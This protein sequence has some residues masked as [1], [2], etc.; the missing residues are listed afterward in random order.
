MV[1]SKITIA[2]SRG[3]S[4]LSDAIAF[5]KYCPKEPNA[6][7]Q[8]ASVLAGKGHLWQAYKLLS[9]KL[10]LSTDGTSSRFNM[11]LV[12]GKTAFLLGK[13]PLARSHFEAANKIT[14][15]ADYASKELSVAKTYQGVAIQNSYTLL[16]RRVANLDDLES[17][18]KFGIQNSTENE[19]AVYLHALILMCK[20][21]Y[22]EASNSFISICKKRQWQ[23]RVS[24]HSGILA[25]LCLERT[26]KFK[27]GKEV[28]EKILRDTS[29]SRSNKALIAFFLGQASAPECLSQAGNKTTEMRAKALVAFH[30][31]SQ[32]NTKE[33]LPLLLAVKEREENYI[34]E[35]LIAVC[36]IERLAA[37]RP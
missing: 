18:S 3:E 20:G 21:E 10:N 15:L 17:L 27:L 4:E 16:P 30:L 8:L 32:K 12:L 9:E 13:R 23:G 5:C 35:S 37:S 1:R 26:E 24:A 22:A 19:Q 29:L 11:Q 14:S 36:E 31:V 33:A 25:F 2:L 7:V 6:F 28:L 34:D